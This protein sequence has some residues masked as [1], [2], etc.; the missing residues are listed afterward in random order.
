MTTALSPSTLSNA[1]QCNVDGGL[2]SNILLKTFGTRTQSFVRR[3]KLSIYIGEF[4]DIN[5]AKSAAL[6][7]AASQPDNDEQ[8]ESSVEAKKILPPRP[9]TNTHGVVLW[10]TK[11]LESGSK[12]LGTYRK[13]FYEGYISKKSRE[14]HGLGTM[15]YFDGRVYH[16]EWFEG[17]RYGSGR[18]IS[19]DG[20]TSWEGRWKENK[21]HGQGKYIQEGEDEYSREGVWKN[22]RFY[23]GL[24]EREVEKIH[25]KVK[26]K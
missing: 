23:R 6:H 26:R 3:G 5:V 2:A 12:Q 19:K 17:L 10:T 1:D 21:R 14:P 8:L 13:S 18:M 7:S 25:G 4:D 9:P 16:G 15:T 11:T 22:G 24:N 20:K